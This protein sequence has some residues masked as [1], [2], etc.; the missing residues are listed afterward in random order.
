MS[1]GFS[2]L[3]PPTVGLATVGCKL[4]QYDTETIREQFVRSGYQI[5]PFGGRADVYVVNSCTVTSRSDRDSRRLARRAKRTN[6]HAFV[7][8]TGCYAEVSSE[9]VAGIPEVDLVVGNADKP[10]LPELVADG[11]AMAGSP[12]G[13]RRGS[14]VPGES[15]APVHVSDITEPGAF[16][17]PLVSHFGEHTRAFMKVQDG[18]DAACT[19][20][21]VRRARGP[22]RSLSL[23]RAI[24]QAKRFLDVGHAEIVLVGVHLGAYGVDLSRPLRLADLVA[25]LVELPGIG[26]VRLSSIEPHEVDDDL[27]SLA[28]DSRKVCRHFH[29]PLQ[30]GDDEILRRMNRP[31]TGGFFADL[32]ANIATRVPAAGIGADVIVGFPGEA[33]RQFHNTHELL[34]GLPLTYLHVFSYSARAGTPAADFPDQVQEEVKKRRCQ[35]LRQLSD[36]KAQA[37]R[38]RL[39]GTAA[40][41]LI[42]GAH[43]GSDA[44]VSGLTD[45]YVRVALERGTAQAGKMVRTRILSTRPDGLLSAVPER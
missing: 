6:P 5:V 1:G 20:C 24:E 33:E 22:S 37:F 35:A 28:A 15:V 11:L 45:N 23:D 44:V 40:V 3:Q 19:Y 9:A 32:I 38:R 30:S 21:I 34:S 27:I 42:E 39:V 12:E 41:V 14:A 10:N 16:D 29:M 2:N 4:N 43:G 18:C 17:G 26:R 8:V 7:V 13:C 25:R 31:Y 36:R